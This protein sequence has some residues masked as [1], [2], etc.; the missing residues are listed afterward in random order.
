MESQALRCTD[1]V[2]KCLNVGG[3]GRDGGMDSY[4]G[5]TRAD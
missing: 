4:P 5:A 2:Y 1:K 3:G